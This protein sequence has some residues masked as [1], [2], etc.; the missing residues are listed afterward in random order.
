M[1]RWP[2]VL[3]LFAAACSNGPEADLASISQAR[4][5]IAEWAL[6]NQQASEGH[7]TGAYARTMRQEIREQLQTT[8]KSLTYPNSPYG[9][10]ISSALRQSDDAPAA[11]LKARADTLKQI[12]DKLESA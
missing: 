1:L 8:A 10:E 12:E 5:L 3:M 9:G 4:S 11:R 7:L 6:V 2:F